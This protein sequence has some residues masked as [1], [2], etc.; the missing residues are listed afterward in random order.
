MKQKKKKTNKALNFQEL[1]AL[2]H[3]SFYLNIKKTV[4]FSLSLFQENHNIH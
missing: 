2:P 3:K 4:K 1:Q